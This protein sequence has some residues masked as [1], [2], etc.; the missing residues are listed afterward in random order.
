LIQENKLRDDFAI[1][2]DMSKPSDE[3]RWFVIDLK[4]EQEVYETY[5]AHARAAAGGVSPPFFPTQPKP[6]ARPWENYEVVGKLIMES[7]VCPNKD[8]EGLRGGKNKKMAG[9][10]KKKSGGD[11]QRLVFKRGGN[12]LFQKE[13]KI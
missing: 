5:V 6:I 3:K 9:K 8:S 7:T 4:S 12:P 2:I 10:K 1:L 11:P 13:K